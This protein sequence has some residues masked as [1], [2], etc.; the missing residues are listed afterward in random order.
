MPILESITSQG[1]FEVTQGKIAGM[2]VMDKVASLTKVDA[3]KALD[4]AGAKGWFT[5]QN[6]Y[7]EVKPFDI[8]V[9]DMVLTLGGKQNISGAM[10][11]DLDL[12]M[13]TGALG[14]SAVV[15]AACVGQTCSCALDVVVFGVI[16][17]CLHAS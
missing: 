9:Q 10:D 11:Y 15:V 2:P 7:L 16:G 8:K 13:P 4:L 3:L 14:Q 5:I 17:Q 1:A 6:G 12:D